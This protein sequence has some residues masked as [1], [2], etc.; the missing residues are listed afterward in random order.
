MNY[1]QGYKNS[2]PVIIGD[3]VWLCESCTIMNGV[4]IGDGGIIGAKSFVI[5]NVPAYSMVSGH[6]ATIIDEEVLWKY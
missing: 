6:P 5:R 1:F 2:T 4:K 3:K